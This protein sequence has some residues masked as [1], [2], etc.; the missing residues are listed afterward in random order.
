M[1]PIYHREKLEADDVDAKL[2]IMGH[3]Y[4]VLPPTKTGKCCFPA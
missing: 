4:R 1:E 2:R 3:G